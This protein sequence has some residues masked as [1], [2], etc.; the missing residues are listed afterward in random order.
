MQR[1]QPSAS[2]LMSIGVVVLG[3]CATRNADAGPAAAGPQAAERRAD[4]PPPPDQGRPAQG[5]PP[6]AYAACDG[7]KQGDS[8]RVKL[9]DREMDG[10][11]ENPPPGASESRLAC[12]P[13][14]PPPAPPK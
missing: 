12:R 10:T 14:G 8:C 9:G 1:P 13:A 7:K 6:E 2:L 3:A 5:P 4:A 11:C